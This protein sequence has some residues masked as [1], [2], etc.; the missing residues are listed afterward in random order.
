[1]GW[2]WGKY[3]VFAHPAGA[4]NPFRAASGLLYFAVKSLSFCH[5]IFL[6]CKIVIIILTHLTGIREE[7]LI[8]VHRML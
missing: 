3:H 4:V 7:M 8:N 1:M 5:P 6:I 2:E